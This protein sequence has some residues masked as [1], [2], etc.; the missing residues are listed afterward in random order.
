MK[1]VLA[2]VQWSKFLRNIP[3]TSDLLSSHS[4]PEIFRLPGG[5]G[6]TTILIELGVQDD[7]EAK[8]SLYSKTTKVYHLKKK[9]KRF[10]FVVPYESAPHLVAFQPNMGEQVRQGQGMRTVYS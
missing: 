8:C 3:L 1:F 9:K 7:N 10:I 6:E 5:D 4:N 2:F